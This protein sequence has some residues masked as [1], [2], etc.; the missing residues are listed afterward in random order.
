MKERFQN[1]I[2]AFLGVIL[3]VLLGNLGSAIVLPSF[4]KENILFLLSLLGI[5]IL[6]SVLIEQVRE[7]RK[8]QGGPSHPSASSPGQAKPR[9]IRPER[10]Y[11]TA[12]ILGVFLSFV[13]LLFMDLIPI[14]VG[15]DPYPTPLQAIPP[16]VMSVIAGGILGKRREAY[17][18]ILLAGLLIGASGDMYMVVKYGPFLPYFPLYGWALIVA[19]PVICELLSWLAAWIRTRTALPAAPLSP[20]TLAQNKRRRSPAVPVFLILLALILL[21]G[22]SFDIYYNVTR[23]HSGTFADLSGIVWSGSQF[24]A[25]GGVGGDRTSGTI[26][27]SSDGR[28]WTTQNVGTS[29]LYNVAWSGSQFVAVGARGTILTSSD[30]RTWTPQTSGISAPL[31]G[32]VWSGSQFVA[33]GTAMDGNTILTSPDGHS[34][35]ILN[36]GTSGFSSL[37]KVVWSGSQF[38]AVGDSILTSPDGRTWTR[39]N[40]GLSNDSIGGVVWSGSQ[41]VA[42]SLGGIILTSPDGRTW[43]TLNSGTSQ[44]LVGV[45]WSGWQFVVVGSGGTI[46]TSADGRTWTHQTSGIS[47]F[48][49]GVVWSG[50]QFVAVGSGGTILA[51]PDGYTWT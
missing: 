23:I 29:P 22:T 7:Q 28:T 32:V 20:S 8:Q 45:A 35:T 48:L 18:A 40:S 10:P 17:S 41:F 49:E 11:L 12:V 39:Q 15:V 24:A 5:C 3:S 25:V 1:G 27:T 47:Q 26:L 21:G 14:W 4:I 6:A 51:S 30:G 44:L 50:S 34:W 37:E 16:L 42:V 46:L 19:D 38:V 13:S 43:T 9:P 2:L 31:Q 33:V 36:S